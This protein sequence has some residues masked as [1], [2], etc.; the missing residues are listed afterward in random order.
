MRESVHVE[1]VR[2]RLLIH[3][4]QVRGCRSLELIDGNQRDLCSLRGAAWDEGGRENRGDHLA[5]PQFTR[6]THL[7]VLHF[8][9]SRRRWL[10]SYRRLSSCRLSESAAE[11]TERTSSFLAFV[12]SSTSLD[13][14]FMVCTNNWPRVSNSAASEGGCKAR[15]HGANEVGQISNAR[16]NRSRTTEHTAP[17]FFSANNSE[18]VLLSSSAASLK[19]SMGNE[20]EQSPGDHSFL[21]VAL[22]ELVDQL[23]YVSR[24]RVQLDRDDIEKCECKSMYPEGDICVDETCSNRAMR[25]ECTSCSKERCRNQNLGKKLWKPVEKFKVMRASACCSSCAGCTSWRDR[26]PR[27][28]QYTE[29]QRPS[30][31]GADQAGRVYHRVRRRGH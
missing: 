12:S 27:A 18:H 1:A 8:E 20:G 28:D 26:I 24:D 11:D 22:M 3:A 14:A 19:A 4:E 29:R 6:H 2:V 7:T 25:V 15:E 30:V 17:R 31:H 9:I 5:G 23:V 10:F 13:A 16:H 21:S